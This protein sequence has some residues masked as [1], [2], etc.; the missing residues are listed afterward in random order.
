MAGQGGEGKGLDQLGHPHGLFIDSQD[1]LYICDSGNYR[2]LKIEKIGSGK[3]TTTV[4]AGQKE[5]Q[6]DVLESICVDK[7]GT[8][9]ILDRSI[10]G[11]RNRV[12]TI[13]TASS[14][15]VLYYR[16]IV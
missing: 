10:D 1:S 11:K 14:L 9:Y 13:S 6:L 3:T 15:V 5:G 4:V 16:R 7:E 12:S 8:M 2:V